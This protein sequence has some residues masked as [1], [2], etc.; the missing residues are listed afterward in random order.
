MCVSVDSAFNKPIVSTPLHLVS[1]PLPLNAWIFNKKNRIFQYAQVN[2]LHST[3][4]WHNGYAN[5][6]SLIRFSFFFFFFWK[7]VMPKGMS[8]T[9]FIHLHLRINDWKINE[10]TKHSMVKIES[11]FKALVEASSFGRKSCYVH[12]ARNQNLLQVIFM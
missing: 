3:A 8:S 10:W 12:T 9:K 1:F 6:W 7:I 4:Q 5:K 11:P 2:S